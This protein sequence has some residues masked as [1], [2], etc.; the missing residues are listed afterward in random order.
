MFESDFGRIFLA[1]ANERQRQWLLQILSRSYRRSEQ[2][3]N[4]QGRLAAFDPI[5]KQG[6]AGRSKNFQFA[7]S[8]TI[9]VPFV[10][11]GICVAAFKSW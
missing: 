11:D 10:V 5:R 8:S 3:F 7:G 6:W 9:A 4:A 1:F 2:E